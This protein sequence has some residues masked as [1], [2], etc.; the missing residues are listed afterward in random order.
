MASVLFVSKPIAAPWNDSG[1][2]LVRDLARGMSRH[3]ATVMVR[4][5]DTPDVGHAAHQAVYGAPTGDGFAPALIDQARVFGA[6][7]GSRNHALWHF[8]FA[9]NPRSCAA[10]GLARRLR[11][12]RCVHTISSAPKDPAA[13]VPRLFADVHVVL[14][15]HTEARL[16]AAGLDPLRMV[17]IAPAIAPLLPV[18][19]AAKAALRASFGVHTTGPLVLYPG[20]LE[21]GE[22]GALMVAAL[23]GLPATTLVL[24]C[25]AKTAGA[26]AAERA[27]L[28]QAQRA[29]L[30]DRVVSLG[31]TPRIHALLA[32][33]DVVALPSVDLY[34]KMDYPLVLLEAMSL[35]QPVVVARG[36][37]AAELCAAD[38][39]LATDAS[40]EALAAT[41]GGVL[42]DADGARALGERARAAVRLRYSHAVMA[43]AY[44]SLYDRLLA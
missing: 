21:F 43:Q 12:M 1:K 32:C 31:E 33:A 30:A 26:K 5:G 7:L 3:R 4:A 16:L 23:A 2:N 22:G 35:G 25:R 10:G 20:D 17:R 44:E 9:P 29:G 24:A 39:A 18:D 38:A 41:L 15:R 34:A 27:L 19:P 36:S 11:A 42:A 14:S 28:A 8:F 6:L 40:P 37:A 13:I